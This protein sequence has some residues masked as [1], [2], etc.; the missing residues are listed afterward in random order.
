MTAIFFKFCN[1]QILCAG[2][3]PPELPTLTDFRP[4]GVLVAHMAEHQHCVNR[5]AVC[6]ASPIF[7]S[8]SS[9]G[10]VKLW[11]RVRFDKV[12]PPVAL[13]EIVGQIMCQITG[14]TCQVWPPLMGPSSSG[15]ASALILYAFLC[16]SQCCL[17]HALLCTYHYAPFFLTRCT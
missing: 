2:P 1:V 13:C 8:A 11:D 15:T 10:T 16:L 7:A 6:D 3:P 12:C 14:T 5:L 4:R 9:D 17:T